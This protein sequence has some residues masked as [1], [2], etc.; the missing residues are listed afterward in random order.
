MLDFGYGSVVSVVIFV[1]IMTL[2]LVYLRLL[3]RR[4]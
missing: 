1:C 3:M 2:S 4:A